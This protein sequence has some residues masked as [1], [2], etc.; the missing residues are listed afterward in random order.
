MSQYAA[1]DVKVLSHELI[2]LLYMRMSQPN[3]FKNKTDIAQ[4]N[5]YI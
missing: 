5:L 3:Q 1:K 2:L 4:V